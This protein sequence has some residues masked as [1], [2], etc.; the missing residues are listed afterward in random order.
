[1]SVVEARYV[2]SRHADDWVQANINEIN[3]SSNGFLEEFRKAQQNLLANVAAGRGNTFAYTGAPGTAPLPIIL[4]YFSGVAAAN[5]GDPTRY[6]STSFTD[7]TF[8]NALAIMNPQPCC[9]TNATTPS[10]AYN[11]MNNAGRRANALAAGLPAN[12]FVA[13]PDVLGST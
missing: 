2:G 5:A 7:A 9:S 4:A 10:F 13:N 11:L 8:L 3:I 1:N 6:N 12:L